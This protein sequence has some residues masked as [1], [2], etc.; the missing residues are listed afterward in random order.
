MQTAGERVAF[1]AGTKRRHKIILHSGTSVL[2]AGVELG[3]K[4]RTSFLTVSSTIVDKLESYFGLKGNL[5]A[6]AAI[7]HPLRL[8][9]AEVNTLTDVITDDVVNE[10]SKQYDNDKD[11]KALAFA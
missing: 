4:S 6:C 11:T 2:G 5:T 9:T 10:V 8:T 3:N 7:E 1:G